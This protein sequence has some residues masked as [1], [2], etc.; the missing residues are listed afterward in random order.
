MESKISSFLS[1][2]PIALVVTLIVILAAVSLQFGVTEALKALFGTASRMLNLIRE[3]EAE[4]GDWADKQL[5]HETLENREKSWLDEDEREDDVVA[6]DALEAELRAEAAQDED[7]A[8][9][10]AEADKIAAAMEIPS[11]TT[12]D[13]PEAT[14]QQPKMPFPKTL[15]P[16]PVKSSKRPVK[17]IIRALWLKL[18]RTPRRFQKALTASGETFRLVLNE[19]AGFKWHYFVLGITFMAVGQVIQAS[20]TIVQI[21]ALRTM[22]EL[23]PHATPSRSGS[24]HDNN[25]TSKAIAHLI[26][27]LSQAAVYMGIDSESA[28]RVVAPLLSYAILDILLTWPSDVLSFAGTSAFSAA[29]GKRVSDR[30]RRFT[31]ACISQDLSFQTAAADYLNTDLDDSVDN[32]LTDM[33]PKVFSLFFDFVR[34]VCILAS[35][36]PM[37]GA[38]AVILA[39]PQALLSGWW[40]FNKYENVNLTPRWR[41]IINRAY[42]M[43]PRPDSLPVGQLAVMQTQLFG[44]E[45]SVSEGSSAGQLERN[46]LHQINSILGWSGEFKRSMLSSVCTVTMKIA[47][48]LR[49]HSALLHTTKIT[50]GGISLTSGVSAVA[51]GYVQYVQVENSAESLAIFFLNR[52]PSLYRDLKRAA[53]KIKAYVFFRYRTSKIA[54]ATDFELKLPSKTT[55]PAHEQEQA[56]GGSFLLSRQETTKLASSKHIQELPIFRNSVSDDLVGAIGRLASERTCLVRAG[57]HQGTHRLWRRVKLQG[58]FDIRDLSFSLPKIPRIEKEMGVSRDEL[59]TALNG[60]YGRA[61]QL[62]QPVDRPVGKILRNLTLSIPAGATVGI[63]GATGCGK[64]TLLSIISRFYEPSEGLITLDG[65]SISDFEPRSL[66]RQIG[67]VPQTPQIFS[68]LTVWQNIIY[69]LEDELGLP[70]SWKARQNNL[71]QAE[72]EQREKDRNRFDKTGFNLE[73]SVSLST[74]SK[75]QDQKA[76]SHVTN[77]LVNN[78]VLA[79]AEAYARRIAEEAARVASIHDLIVTGGEGR[80]KFEKGYDTV[81]HEG[82]GLS[83]GEKQLLAIARA[84]ARDPAIL[85]LDEPTSALDPVKERQLVTTLALAA[86]GRTTIIVA[87]RLSTLRK[88]DKIV[89]LRNGKV[90]EE[91]KWATLMARPNGLFRAFAGEEEAQ[92]ANELRLRKLQRKARKQG[93]S[94]YNVVEFDCGDNDDESDNEFV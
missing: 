51:F 22:Q 49:M 41:K 16:T 37:L 36:D 46:Q 77:H 50:G 74:K 81:L 90:A 32:F 61:W 39:I 57:T 9:A 56:I 52:V 13:A 40:N 75:S 23:D 30:Q 76:V 11:L 53:I 82:R 71:F 33:L 10:A 28:R 60:G 65:V 12:A 68:G 91:G 19:S 80:R 34:T 78:P 24:N 47:A 43:L 70:S 83:G 29:R 79:E 66:R 31:R 8:A 89:F 15:F 2:N 88:V 5:A 4:H 6:D 26:P 92:R 62:A 67:F 48:G 21:A 25:L 35:L 20:I 85:I 38:L 3:L 18:V 94:D 27:F 1:S 64:S 63:A 84:V 54:P 93:A 45:E 73:E 86:K 17:G 69:G 72:E 42:E 44:L 59:Q 58:A 87:H 14:Q 7:D 55:L